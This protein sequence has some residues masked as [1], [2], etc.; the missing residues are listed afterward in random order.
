MTRRRFI[1]KL[2]QI[3]SL[4]VAGASAFTQR[5]SAQ[6]AKLRKFVRAVRA[7]E[8]PGTVKPL[9]DIREP[10]KWSG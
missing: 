3:C 10:S 7:R 6:T 8:Y 9:Q 5:A 1:R 2:A 4:I